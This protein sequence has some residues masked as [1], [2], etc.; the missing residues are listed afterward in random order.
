[1]PSA[2]STLKR[3]EGYYAGKLIDD[4]GLRGLRYGDAQIS[5]NTVDLL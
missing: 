2:G 3:P 5:E 1:M 4:A